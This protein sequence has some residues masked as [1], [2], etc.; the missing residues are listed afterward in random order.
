MARGRKKGQKNEKRGRR[1]N[2]EGSVVKL[3]GN[4]KKPYA[5]YV[6]VVQSNSDS[7]GHV[8]KEIKRKYAGSFET[9]QEAIK[10]LDR[11]NFAKHIPKSSLLFRDI[12][13]MWMQEYQNN[14]VIK[15]SD[16]AIRTHTIAFNSCKSLH[17]R[18]FSDL[19]I[20]DLKNAIYDASSEMSLNSRSR[21]KTLFNFIYDYAIEH[22]IIEDNLARKFVISDI[23]YQMNCAQ[24][25][26]PSK[27]LFSIQDINFLKEN[28]SI[29]FVKIILILLYT[30]VRLNEIINLLQ[31]N[32]Y[33][34]KGYMIGGS[35][36]EAGKNR[37]IPIHLEIVQYI[38]YFL[39]KNKDK[40]YL[41]YHQSQNGQK[42]YTE[43]TFYK[44]F[45]SVIVA[46]G[47][48]EDYTPHCTRHTFVT[49]AKICGMND[50]IIKK[51][52]GHSEKQDVTENVYTHRS[53]DVILEDFKKFNYEK[54]VF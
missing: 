10:E 32:I 38:E 19:T 54:E 23:V 50:H 30:G 53:I 11:I 22:E 48:S 29:D 37:I 45:M 43:S 33:I 52:V 34:D 20:G 28:D 27:K 9:E 14:S 18:R 47:F 49:A 24:A 4:R 6:S 46:L 15:R 31:S 8:S 39:S 3:P 13:E 36:S 7:F 25:E 42:K 41:M 5:I 26:K 17:D 1:Y 12:Y 35:K 40:E 2:G 21:L 16:T 51:I 44:E